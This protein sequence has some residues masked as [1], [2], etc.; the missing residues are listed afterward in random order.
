MTIFSRILLSLCLFVST[1]SLADDGKMS[2][3]DA[4][5]L[6]LALSRG[7]DLYRHDQA[8]WHTTDALREDIDNLADTGIRGWVVTKTDEG[9]LTTFWRPKSDGFAGVYSAIWT[10]KKVVERQILK[11]ENQALSVEQ[12]ALIEARQAVDAGTLER[13]KK[14]P[15]NTVILP[16]QQE[17][18]P[19]LVYYLTPQTSNQSIP[20]GGHYRFSVKDNK[21][22]NQRVFMKSCLELALSSDEEADKKAVGFGVTHLLDS[23]PTE[24]HVFSA[25]AAQKPIYV[26]TTSNDAVWAVEISGGQPRVRKLK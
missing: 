20:F 15:F 2:E 24:L 5:A 1:P 10:G 12:M 23:V 13:C 4:K 18:G 9:W 8:A 26:S 22:I 3:S 19:I 11:A 25:F 7:L 16:P 17:G 6:Q 14:N 21:V